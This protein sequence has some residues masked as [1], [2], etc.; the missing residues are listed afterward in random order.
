MHID[1]MWAA[2]Q[3]WGPEDLPDILGLP[4]ASF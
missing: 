1:S 4:L 3:P 2:G